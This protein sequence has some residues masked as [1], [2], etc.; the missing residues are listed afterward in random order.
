MKQYDFTIM[1]DGTINCYD[2]ETGDLLGSSADKYEPTNSDFWAMFDDMNGET[3]DLNIFNG[4]SNF[5][6]IVGYVYPCLLDDDGFLT[7]EYGDFY[8]CSIEFE[9]ESIFW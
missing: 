3:F 8:S 5:A 7:G 4:D 1:I 6:P 2:A 9:N